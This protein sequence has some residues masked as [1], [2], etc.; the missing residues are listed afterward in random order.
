MPYLNS[1]QWY[2]PFYCASQADRI[3]KINTHVLTC[4]RIQSLLIHITFS[5]M[6]ECSAWLNSFS[7]HSTTDLLSFHK[8]DY[9]IKE[10]DRVN[11]NTFTLRMNKNCKTCT[12]KSKWTLTLVFPCASR[13]SLSS[14]EHSWRLEISLQKREINLKFLPQTAGALVQFSYLRVSMPDLLL[15]ISRHQDSL[16][17]PIKELTW[18]LPLE[19]LLKMIRASSNS[20]SFLY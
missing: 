18:L 4:R 7:S 9:S 6:T 12:I 19:Y 13:N 8:Y 14:M 5:S 16:Q 10:R 17:T 20:I 3:P 11:W 15:C 1:K 2:N